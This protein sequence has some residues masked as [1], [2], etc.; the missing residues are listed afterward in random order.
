MELTTSVALATILIILISLFG[1]VKYINAKIPS[2][3][4][5]DSCLHAHLSNPRLLEMLARRCAFHNI[6][7]AVASKR[8]ITF[9]HVPKAGGSSVRY[10]LH[11]KVD[12]MRVR[13]GIV[14][15][16]LLAS[17]AAE[18]D[19][20][21]I[22]ML[23]EPLALSISFYTYVNEQRFLSRQ[24]EANKLWNATFHKYPI[25]WSAD[26]FIQKAFPENLLGHFLRDVV[27][28]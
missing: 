19:N 18:P 2:C 8:R 10:F 26:P 12:R 14:H 3:Q 25:P 4:D 22:T 5:W 21:F 16:H 13:T 24:A 6:S 15:E 11:Q 7:Q 27:N 23:R 9:T 17:A 1:T 20:L 28:T